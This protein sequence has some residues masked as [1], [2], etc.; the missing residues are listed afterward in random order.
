VSTNVRWGPRRARCA[1]GGKWNG[2]AVPKSCWSC[3]SRGGCLWPLYIWPLLSVRHNAGWCLMMFQ[4]SS[5]ILTL[6]DVLD[7]SPG[8]KANHVKNNGSDRTIGYVLDLYSVLGDTVFGC[9]SLHGRL[10]R[11]AHE[12]LQ[13]PQ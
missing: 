2:K 7:W 6:T 9:F 11:F 1:T 3:V 12:K 8:Q 13:L 5:F 4:K 10:R